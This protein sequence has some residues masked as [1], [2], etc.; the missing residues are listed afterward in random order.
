MKTKRFPALFLCLVMLFS[1]LPVGAFAE[2]GTPEEFIPEEILSPFEE[3]PELL[4]EPEQIPEEL[5]EE[6]C[7]IPE[8]P[9]DLPGE[10]L[11][12]ELA[13]VSALLYV[14]PNYIIRLQP[15]N[16][17]D[18]YIDIRPG[19]EGRMA[20]SRQEAGNGQFWMEGDQLWF[21]LPNCPDSFIAPDGK[22]FAKWD[23]ESPGS[24]L[25]IQKDLT[26]T[27]QWRE[28]ANSQICGIPPADGGSFFLHGI[29]WR[30]IG[31]KDDAWLMILDYQTYDIQTYRWQE[32]LDYCNTLYA[33]F[34]GPEQAAVL[35]TTQTDQAYGE[36]AP[37]NLENAA[38]FLLSASEALTYFNSNEDRGNDWWL[39][40]SNNSD[41]AAFINGGL[42]ACADITESTRF[43]NARPAFQ[44]DPKSVF[45]TSAAAGGKSSAAAGSG[46]FGTFQAHYEE[47][48]K[49][50]LLDSSRSGFSASIS[51][52]DFGAA[53]TVTYSGAKTGVKEYVSAMLCGDDG[54]ILYYASLTPAGTG[55]G[56]W[57]LAR[58][59][60]LPAGTY[61]LKVFSEQ[62]NESFF[63]DYAGSPV[64][65]TVKAGPLVTFK[66]Y[67]G[68]VL[69]EGYFPLGA[70][71][72]YEG[73]TPGKPSSNPR[74]GY[75]FNGWDPVPGPA[76]ETAVYTA[77]FREETKNI[78]TFDANGGSGTMADGSYFA[79]E[80]QYILP[81]C[82]FTAPEGMSF[83]QWQMTK[84]NADGTFTDYSYNAGARVVGLTGDVTFRAGWTR[85]SVV[86][87]VCQGNTGTAVYDS[88]LQTFTATPAEGYSFVHWEY[89]ES[90]TAFTPVDQEWPTANPYTPGS[91]P[92]GI[93]TAVFEARRYTVTVQANEAERGSAG[94]ESGSS[95]LSS[96]EV[97]YGSKVTLT[98][99]AGEGYKF[100]EWQVEPEDVTVGSDNSF[101]MPA[102]DVTA[103]AVF[104]PQ[105]APEFKTHT[106]LL[107][108]QIGVNFYMDLSRL[109]EE[110]RKN[111]EMEFTVNGRT[112]TD[113][114]DATHTNPNGNGY[115]GFTCYITSV[116]MA[117][118]I[119]AV[120][121]YGDDQTVSQKYS[122]KQYV[123][124]VLKNQNSFSTNAVALVSAI[125]DYGS[126]V[127][128]F[129]AEANGWQ[130]GTDHKA[131]TAASTYTD[132]DVAAAR[133]AVEDYTIV[134]NTGDTGIAEVKYSLNLQSE[135]SI[136]LYLKVKEGYTGS[137]AATMG[138]N[139]VACTRLSDGR[140]R[141]TIPN[142]QAHQLGDQ[143]TVKVSAGGEFTITVSALSYV[144]TALNSSE[145]KFT[146]SAAKYAVSS[147][148]YYYK[149]T[150]EY[151]AHPNE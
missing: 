48:R 20:A 59:A 105:G 80:S 64:A 11:S 125:A 120:L 82:G 99:T 8:L 44:M 110:D 142:I 52:T 140:Y 69:Q 84:E 98:A 89:R 34:D 50:T 70:T 90:E 85:S 91:V 76:T 10:L 119:T 132:G 93:Y 24:V 47:R 83:A 7:F 46:E 151:Q 130:V 145:E 62:Q 18:G 150:T 112:Q 71:P 116:E 49:A 148:Y 25:E 57:E 9:E 22:F 107:S 36:L 55:A 92:N 21:K 77:Q 53:L 2:D 67:D 56:T 38:L 146:N 28:G 63:T 6:P 122:A 127:Q 96:K 45:F 139:S 101:T 137:V 118:K 3:E 143:Y 14:G 113:K 136:Y 131:M 144:N 1:L 129:L 121:H 81:V 32:A 117:D 86:V 58:P 60:D 106:L 94:L 115:F 128:P 97:S 103:T 149:A 133:T 75:V 108:G 126:Y 23:A 26:L 124:H 66:N 5:S 87:E 141:I 79:F 78:V 40:S 13:E 72:V 88:T 73:V 15:G 123:D 65:F 4:P 16:G 37:A 114:F 111:T 138:G 51:S 30:V 74:R 12:E 54:S 31:M 33:S 35:P 104:V 29:Q 135:T 100:Q 109:S 39:R 42:V 61:T 41:K 102:S 27:A 43:L 134:R 95:V 17:S 68:A 147:L 19:D